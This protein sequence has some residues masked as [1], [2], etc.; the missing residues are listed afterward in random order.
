MNIVKFVRTAFLHRT[1]LTSASVKSVTLENYLVPFSKKLANDMKKSQA[2]E[3]FAHQ[4]PN[5]A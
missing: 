2:S 1:P 4:N 5:P 3:C